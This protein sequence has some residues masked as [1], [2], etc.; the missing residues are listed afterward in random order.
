MKFQTT[1]DKLIEQLQ[2]KVKAQEGQ[3]GELIGTNEELK[4]GDTVRQHER[5]LLGKR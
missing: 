5:K 4:A 1:Q 3:I 2:A